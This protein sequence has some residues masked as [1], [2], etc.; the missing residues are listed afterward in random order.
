MAKPEVTTVAQYVA[1]Q[2]AHVRRALERV[3]ATIRKTL[4][5]A[6]EG[7]AYQMPIY[8]VD[9]RMVLYFA[10]YAKH[11]AIYPAT[12]A[13][14]DALGDAAADLLHSKATLRFGYDGAVP[15]ALIARIA[16]VRA[17]EVASEAA[18]AKATAKRRGRK[19]TT[20]A[21]AGKVPA[22]S[23]AGKRT[24]KATARTRAT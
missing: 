18:A 9:G 6:V 22:K 3:R 17:A 2:P 19:G 12:P 24:T 11:Y 23:I 20:K 5:S 7:I 10:G 21:S 16:K 8:K 4:P 15:T 1:A 14:I 13:V